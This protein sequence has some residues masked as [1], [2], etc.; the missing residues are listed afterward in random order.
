M[1]QLDGKVALITGGSR[2]LG[3]QIATA[4]AQRGATVVISSRKREACVAA[5]DEIARRTGADAFGIGC[6]I[7]HW[8]ECDQLV[9]RVYDQF[10]RVD[11]LVNNA[12]SSPPYPSLDAVSEEL[13]DKVVAVNLKGHFRLCALIGT[14]MA[15]AGGGAIINV[16]STA[17]VSPSPAE[18]PYGAAK[19]GLSTLT[20]GFARAFAPTVR[21][22]T[23]V[24]GPFLTDISKAWDMQA[25]EQMA[26]R[27][28]PLGRAGRPEEIVGAA[29]YLASDASS[30]TTGSTITMDGGLTTG[31]G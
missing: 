24:P 13:F 28:I 9:E 25:F 31:R 3:L 26:E 17:S 29:L 6:H 10:E 4:F 15:A 5:A 12:G 27:S 8:D 23:I 30:Y 2:G 11:I 22:N 7:G 18:L 16:S 14:R 20:V 19:A 21:V 1:F